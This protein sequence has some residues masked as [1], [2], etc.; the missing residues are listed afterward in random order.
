MPDYPVP[1]FDQFYRHAELTR[2]LTDYAPGTARPGEPA[3]HRQEP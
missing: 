3:L 2:L 1:R